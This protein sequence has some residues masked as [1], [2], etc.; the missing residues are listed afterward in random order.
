MARD[1]NH[2]PASESILTAAGRANA[3]A[4]ARVDL[5]DDAQSYSEIDMMEL[6]DA[7]Y[8]EGDA[9]P[10]LIRALERY[11]RLS[12]DL[13]SDRK[14]NRIFA[15]KMIDGARADKDRLVAAWTATFGQG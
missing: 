15:A 10:E 6:A 4:C 8:D 14:I 13:A 5:R 2:R 12:G 7:S 3:V 11:D 1:T 9:S